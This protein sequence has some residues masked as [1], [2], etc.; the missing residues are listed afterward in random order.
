MQLI[1]RQN[2]II[3]QD[4]DT[5]AT[6][7]TWSTNLGLKFMPDIVNVKLI[8]AKGDA[9]TLGTFI[10]KVEEL[11]N[12]LGTFIDGS[13]VSP[14]ITFDL[15]SVN[16]ESWHFRIVDVF[17]EL[18]TAFLGEIVIHLEFLKYNPKSL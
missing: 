9:A 15:A 5:A 10:I 1:R 11:D 3:T 13:S 14:N 2:V 8:V 6:D 4:I 7:S 18:N 12:F 16:T 17:G